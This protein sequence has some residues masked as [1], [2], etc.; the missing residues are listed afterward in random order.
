MT[1]MPPKDFKF[2]TFDNV[3][4]MRDSETISQ[5]RRHA[6]RDIGVARRLPN[7]RRSRRRLLM[8][9]LPGSLQDPAGSADVLPSKAEPTDVSEDIED[10]IAEASTQQPP[11]PTEHG[12]QA[13][14]LA[15][16]DPAALR[17]ATQ[18]KM[19]PFDASPITADNVVYTLVQYYIYHYHENAFWQHETGSLPHEPELFRGYVQQ[20]A[21]LAFNDDFTMLCLLSASASRMQDRDNVR[22]VEIG[23]Q[24]DLA[25]VKGLQMLQQRLPTFCTASSCSAPQ[26]PTRATLRP[27]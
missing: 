2:I 4:D 22:I 8:P 13:G 21:N 12:A 23:K 24:R 1:D 9:L 14:P 5:I 26:N 11:R 16:L 6:M 17:S 15:L 20:K 18:G 3:D 25:T 19:D 10:P 27:Y 7:S